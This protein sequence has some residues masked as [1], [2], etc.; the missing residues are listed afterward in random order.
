MYYFSCAQ[1]GSIVM[2]G[3]IGCR[4]SVF[5]QALDPHSNTDIIVHIGGEE[6]DKTVAEVVLLIICFI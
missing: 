1:G 6:P 5:S 2:S 4:K 3:L